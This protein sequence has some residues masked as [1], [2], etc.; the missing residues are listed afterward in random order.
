M[1]TARQT[2]AAGPPTVRKVGALAD[3]QIFGAARGL[4]PQA[5]IRV[6]APVPSLSCHV[7]RLVV[8]GGVVY[9]KCSI[10]GA[11]LGS[12]LRGERGSWEQ[13]RSAQRE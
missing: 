13:V 2:R 6:A 10:L 1:R 8:D 12:V 3:A 5:D 4:W 9:A 7:R 11:Q